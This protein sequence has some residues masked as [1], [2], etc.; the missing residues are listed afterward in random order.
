VCNPIT[1]GPGT[2]L[3]PNGTSVKVGSILWWTW[4]NGLVESAPVAT[5]VTTQVS[6][7]Q[8]KLN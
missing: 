4:G 5:C 7:A 8:C 6:P 3:P 1:P 2:S